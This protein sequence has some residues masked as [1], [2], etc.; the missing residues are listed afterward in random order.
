MNAEETMSKDDRAPHNRS[1]RFDDP[2]SDKDARRFWDKVDRQS[3]EAC[4]K[5]Q[6]YTDR[7]GYGRFSLNGKKERAHRVAARLD[8]RDP[9]GKVVR[10]TCDNPSCVNPAHLEVGTQRDN[11]RDKVQRGRQARGARNGR[12]HL[13]RE[14][15]V[16]IRNDSRPAKEVAE[17]FG[18]T[19]SNIREIRSGRS[20]RHVA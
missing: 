11:M 14:E 18:T 12:S 7:D 20:W 1:G 6:A 8:G 16:A 17:R 2:I 3:E 9:T 10:H 19:A 15:V 4:W 5:W 13:S